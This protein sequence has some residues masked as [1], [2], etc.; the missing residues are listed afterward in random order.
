MDVQAV[1]DTPS[2]LSELANI[3]DLEVRAD[4][5]LAPMTGL[6]TGGPAAALVFPHTAH[7]VAAVQ[8]WARERRVPC[9]IVS[10]GTHVLVSDQ[11]FPGIVIDLS[12]EFSFLRER[13]DLSGAHVWEIGAA[14]PA[15]RVL[16]RALVRGLSASPFASVTGSIGGALILG[17][18]KPGASLRRVQAIVGG[19]PCWLAGQELESAWSVITALLSV[20]LELVPADAGTLLGEL[21]G[22]DRRGVGVGPVFRDPSEDSA[23]R[24]IALAG[25]MHSRLGAAAFVEGLPNRIVNLGGATASDAWALIRQ[26]QDL[27]HE[28]TGVRLQRALKLL[29]V[30]E[31]EVQV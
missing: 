18:A 17:L 24:L 27:V 7:A 23:A 10:G 28:R 31:G 5:L 16:R 3:P 30:F 1:A 2:W 8:R 29:G 22:D 14:C 9:A 20:E 12:P 26:V 6:R 13:R 11:G 19:A 21:A 15:H 25:L 4:V